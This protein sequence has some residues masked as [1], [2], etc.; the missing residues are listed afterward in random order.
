MQWRRRHRP[1]V[2]TRFTYSWRLPSRSSAWT[3]GGLSQA[4]LRQP[5]HPASC[6]CM[7]L[8]L[9]LRVATAKA[10]TMF[11]EAALQN[12]EALHERFCHKISLKR[13]D[14]SRLIAANKEL[15]FAIY[16]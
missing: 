2:D 8:M 11:D 9:F 15:H 13:P 12:V 1:C 4:L 10:A 7:A 5:V 6:A 3:N 16:L 14:A